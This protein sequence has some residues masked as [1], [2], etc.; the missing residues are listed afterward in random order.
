MNSPVISK[1]RWFLPWI[2][3]RQVY[4]HSVWKKLGVSE[5][6]ICNGKN[7]FSG[8]GVSE[9]RWL[10]PLEQINQRLKNRCMAWAGMRYRKRRSNANSIDLISGYE[11]ITTLLQFLDSTYDYLC[12]K[13][14]HVLVSS[15]NIL[16]W[17]I[18]HTSHTRRNARNVGKTKQIAID[19]YLSYSGNNTTPPSD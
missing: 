11:K 6:K 2:R 16:Y 15:V 12:S 17:Y 10:R 14:C 18:K 4:D 3:Q 19:C 1:N 13:R 8:P 5:G 7:K 9:I